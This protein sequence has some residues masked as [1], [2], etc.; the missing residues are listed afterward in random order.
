MAKQPGV[1]VVDVQPTGW[2]ADKASSI[3]QDWPV[4]YSDLTVYALSDTLAV[5]A[6]NVAERQKV[7]L[8]TEIADRDEHHAGRIGGPVGAVWVHRRLW[9]SATFMAGTARVSLRA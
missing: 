9:R 6:M 3:M 8:R 2:T 5:P 1:Q 4:K 7:A